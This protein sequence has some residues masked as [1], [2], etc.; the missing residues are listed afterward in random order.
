MFGSEGFQK[1]D[2][3]LARALARPTE[4]NYHVVTCYYLC[5]ALFRFVNISFEFL[6]TYLLFIL[7]VCHVFLER[8]THGCSLI[9]CAYMIA[10]MY[11]L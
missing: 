10:P 5:E 3:N 8:R 4:G 9:S 6:Y 7:I 2:S 11:A 1:R